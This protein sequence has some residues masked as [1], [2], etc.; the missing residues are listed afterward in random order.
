MKVFITILCITFSFS[1]SAQVKGNGNLV[2]INKSHDKIEHIDISLYANVQVDVNATETFVEIIVEENLKDL[3]RFDV[4]NNKLILDQKEWVKPSKPIQITIGAPDLNEIT[5]GT[6]ETVVV[7]GLSIDKFTAIADVGK[8]QLDG[9]VSTL[10]AKVGTGTVDAKSLK[11]KIVNAIT[12]SWGKIS[13]TD[14]EVITGKIENNGQLTYTS[15]NTV[16]NASSTEDGRIINTLDNEVVEDDEEEFANARF[17]KFKLKNNSKSRKNYY[18]I[19]PKKNGSRFSYGFPMNAGQT[20]EKDWT[21]GT[22]L[23]QQSKFGTKKLLLII[24]ADDEGET[25]LIYTNRE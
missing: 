17:I 18:V 16:V 3:I 7:E 9:S 21:I 14:P 13:V 5:Q 11:V 12:T 2:T 1:L 6:H 22:K 23:Y 20:R 15:I 24:T 8:V 19:G 25:V 4:D 10:T